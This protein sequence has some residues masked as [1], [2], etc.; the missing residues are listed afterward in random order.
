MV[1]AEVTV[2]VAA[3]AVVPGLSVVTGRFALPVFPVSGRRWR[4][5]LP[6]EECKF[7]KVNEGLIVWFAGALIV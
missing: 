6:L 7:V 4:R 3:A 2:V 1:A 5:P